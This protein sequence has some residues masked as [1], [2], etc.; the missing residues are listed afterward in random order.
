MHPGELHSAA[1]V[2]A[3]VICAVAALVLSAGAATAAAATKS[4]T[5]ALEGAH[6]K[7]NVEVPA[8]M[9]CS[10]TESSIS[11]S[12]T[13]QKAATLEFAHSTAGGNLKSSGVVTIGTVGGS[14]AQ[15]AGKLQ[16]NG[17]GPVT[18]VNAMVGGNVQ[19][20]AEPA[21]G[22]PNEICNTTISGNLQIQDNA[23]ETIVGEH[24]PCGEGTDHISGKVRI[25]DN[26]V[27]G[28]PAASIAHTTIAKNLQCQGNSTLAGYQQSSVSVGGTIQGCAIETTCNPEESCRATGESPGTAFLEI[29]TNEP[30]FGPEI[31]LITFG[32]PKIGCST[33]GTTNAVAT[34]EVLNPAPGAYKALDYQAL[35]KYAAIAEKK[36]R[37]GESGSFGYLCFEGPEEFM[38]ATGAPA[39]P[40]PGGFYGELPECHVTVGKEVENPPCVIRARYGPRSLEKGEPAYEVEFITSAGDPRAGP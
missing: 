18:L 39:K 4:C 32:P 22:T 31:V 30:S 26:T 15:I 28:A 25:R 37:I 3:A 20:E 19:I 12:V 1:A 40:G 17:G 36:H 14:E 10:I 34:Y 2:V 8:G 13:V 16:I 9:S 7:G 11:G 21:D 35:G 27:T 29:D 24:P 33:S 6:V 5:G 38:T 23:T